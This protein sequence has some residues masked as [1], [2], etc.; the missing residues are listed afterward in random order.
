MKHDSPISAHS[1]AIQTR[2]HPTM[3]LAKYRWFLLFVGLPVMLSACYY[4]LIASD[5]FVTE[6]RF[7]I[8]S[9]SQR[10]AQ[11][12]TLANLVQTTGLSTGQEQ[13]YEVIDYLRS[14]NALKELQGAVDV[15]K[16]YSA[17]HVDFIS[18]FPAIFS[19]NTFENLY[20]YYKTK[21][22]SRFDT[23]TGTTVL[24]VKAFTPSEAFRINARLLEQSEAL[25]NRLN[26][27]AQSRGIAE[28]ERRV[29]IAQAR[30]KN[31]RIALGAYR[32]TEELI[33]PAKQATGVLDISN[34]M[35]AERAVL[36]AELRVMERVTPS[37]P[38]LPALRARV[39]AIGGAIGQ[40]ERRIVGSQGAIASKIGGFEQEFATQMLSAASTALEQARTES[41]KQQFYLER[42]V[43]PTEPDMALFPQRLKS[44]LVFSAAMLCIYMIGWMIVVGIRE[45]APEH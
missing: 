34:K 37:N 10:S 16:A 21:V 15:N 13:S 7:V 1:G 24:T 33:D 26:Q 4:G 20:V 12:S 9:P 40:Q 45:H 3:I 2:P 29:A 36:E 6:S 14:R 30:V 11:L 38:S 42:V 22:E 44:I 19:D 25:V 41:Q 27:R 28:A 39:A 5:Q 31:A 35:I 43:E 32:N 23:E 18:R 17:P 8:K